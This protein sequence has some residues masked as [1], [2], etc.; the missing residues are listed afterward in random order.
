M[1]KSNSTAL[2]VVIVL[3]GVSAWAAQ[4]LG[5]PEDQPSAATTAGPVAIVD[6][7]RIFN[8]CEQIRDLNEVLRKQEVDV[9]T[10]AKTRQKVIEDKQIELSAF[11]PGTPDFHQRRRDLIR[12]GTEANV[13]LKVKEQDL[14]AQKFD[15]TKIVYEKASKIVGQIANER[16]HSVVLQYKAFSP[17]DTDQSLASI[18][19]MIQERAVVH[20]DPN[21][22]IT[23]E[24]IRRINE[25]YRAAGGKKQLSPPSE[26]GN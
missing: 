17:D 10:E 19:R 9:Q 24:V 16:G 7:V 14:E 13:W 22:D 21:I 3:T 26:S 25:A 12:L 2:F 8:E 6:F 23:N 18:R 4:T 20:A 5:G 11:Q 1:S 15:W